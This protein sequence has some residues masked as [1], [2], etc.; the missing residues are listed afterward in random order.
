M[1]DPFHLHQATFPVAYPQLV[2]E[3]VAERGFDPREVLVNAGLPSNMLEQAGSF[4]TPMQYT[5]ITVAAAQLI[6]DMG[7]GIEKGLRMRPTAHGFL[8]YALMSCQNLRDA[9]L[10]SLKFMTIRQR[11][12]ETS[13]EIQGDRC[14]ITLQEKHSFGPTRHF[15][16]EGMSVGLFRSTQYL[17]DA[18][19]PDAELW[20][21]Y[22][23]PDYFERY[24]DRLPKV[25]FGMPTVKL[26]LPVSYL[27][28][29][30]RMADPVASRE[31]IAQ[32]E[33]ELQSIGENDNFLTAVRHSI[34]KELEH[35][36]RLD[37]IASHF[38]ISART[39]KRRLQNYG[40]TFQG[41]VDEVRFEKAKTLMSDTS[42]NLQ[43][44]ATV[45]GY[46]DPANFTRAFRKWSGHNPSVYR[47][48]LLSGLIDPSNWIED[49]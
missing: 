49:H 25:R 13:F 35:K 32:C 12:I 8:G 27:D 11:H 28:R 47:E 29:P 46:Q 14:V 37:V 20:F 33:R 26:F 23:Q 43:D 3:I 45:L 34:G 9:L 19:V 15:F 41:L 6:G 22:P 48:R 7:I 42:L 30:L 39:L 21:D 24:R 16:M 18:E 1:K 10:L 40:H 5:Q 38:F 36:P 17:L 44:I 4:I 31:A 2:L